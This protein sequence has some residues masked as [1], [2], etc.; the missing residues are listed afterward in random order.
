MI[1]LSCKPLMNGIMAYWT[2]VKSAAAYNITLYINDQA[3]SKR[4]NER[5]EM[6]CTFTGL[7]AVDGVTSSTI[8]RASASIVTVNG[9]GGYSTPSHSG[10]DY[11]VKVEAENRNGEIIDSSDKI[12][13]AV[14][15]F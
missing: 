8:F 12:K 15:E 1:R 13:C 6:Y 11:Y 4:V 2:E 14:R 9:G 3:I 10:K 5:T 7:A